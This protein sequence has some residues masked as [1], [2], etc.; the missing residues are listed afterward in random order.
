MTFPTLFVICYTKQYLL[1]LC[2]T[3]NL[4]V[5]GSVMPFLD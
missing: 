3:G 2:Q 1:F 4:K 5:T